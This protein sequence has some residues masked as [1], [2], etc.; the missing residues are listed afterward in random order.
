MSAVPQLDREGILAL[1]RQ[2][3]DELAASGSTAVLFRRTVSAF[4]PRSRGGR[5]ARVRVSHMICE[6]GWQRGDTLRARCSAC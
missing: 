5:P 1:L 4:S 6:Y 3:S 2:V